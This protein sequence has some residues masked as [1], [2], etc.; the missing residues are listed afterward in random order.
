MGKK[1]WAFLLVWEMIWQGF[2]FDEG[3]DGKSDEKSLFF[4]QTKIV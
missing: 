4:V 2:L 3:K 1:I